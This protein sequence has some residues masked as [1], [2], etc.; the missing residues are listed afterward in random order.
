MSSSNQSRMSA[1][2]GVG[3]SPSHVQSPGPLMTVK[4]AA[5]AL[6]FSERTLYRWITS[7]DLPVRRLGRSIRIDRGELD[8]FLARH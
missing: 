2:I 7:G 4:D 6:K 3:K 1:P 8:R 5:A